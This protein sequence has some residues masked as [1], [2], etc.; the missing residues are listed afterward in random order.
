MHSE[1]HTVSCICDLK[2]RPQ[3]RSKDALGDAHHFPERHR[4][5]A[6]PAWTTWAA[7][8]G[9]S[10]R[11]G[12]HHEG[13]RHMPRLAIDALETVL[14]VSRLTQVNDRTPPLD[15]TEDMCSR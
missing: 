12:L 13:P 10:L 1:A 8:R 3:V 11:S 7:G 4:P 14:A 2:G 5:I 9:L 15:V 6:P